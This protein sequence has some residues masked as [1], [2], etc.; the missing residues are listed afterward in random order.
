MGDTAH[1]ND[2]N[3]AYRSTITHYLKYGYTINIFYMKY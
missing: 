2:V 3:L 1:I